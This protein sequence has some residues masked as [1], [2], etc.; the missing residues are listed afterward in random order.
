MMS[1]SLLLLNPLSDHRFYLVKMM[2]ARARSFN[3]L[4][5]EDVA[6]KTANQIFHLISKRSLLVPSDLLYNLFPFFHSP[7]FFHLNYF[8]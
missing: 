5:L 3:L 8:H 1:V 4:T 2:H 7:C 6:Q